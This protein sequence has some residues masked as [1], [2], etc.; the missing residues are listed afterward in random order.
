[1]HT[2][3]VKTVFRWLGFTA[4]VVR[5]FSRESMLRVLENLGIRDHK[6]ADCVA[7]CVLTHGYEGG[8]YGVDG[9][10]V[11]L[12]ELMDPLNG[13]Q[14]YSLSEKPKLFFIQACQGS[15]E[16][17]VVFLQSDGPNDSMETGIVCDARMP[18]ESNKYFYC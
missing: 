5:D 12:R 18:R 11:A 16:Q 1:M 4:E 8:V 9:K 3:N 14:C 6:Q 10:K 7:C 2:E 13:H 17:Q 15:N